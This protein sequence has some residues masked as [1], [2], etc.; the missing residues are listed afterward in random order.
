MLPTQKFSA[1]TRKP[2]PNGVP[3]RL[4]PTA[5]SLIKDTQN[6][7]LLLKVFKRLLSL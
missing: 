5:V 6:V 2:I 7:L 3:Y 1:S 4:A